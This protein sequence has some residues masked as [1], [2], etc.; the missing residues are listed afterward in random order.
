MVARAG[1][2]QAAFTAGELD[3][4]LYDRTSLKYF[5]TGLRRAE[6]VIITPQGGLRQRDGMRLIGDL[7]ANA[8]RIL[9]FDASN[10][11]S[12]DMVFAG[13][14]CKV[15][16]ATSETASITIA[17]ISALLS[18]MTAAQRLDTMLLFH[19]D[20]QSKRLRITDTGWVVDNLPYA[21]IQNYDYGGVYSNGIPAV[22]R[23]EFVGLTSGTTIFTLKV[24]QQETNSITFSATPATMIS[25]IQA[26][27][28]ALPNVASGFT[29]ANTGT[30]IYTIS[31]SGA[32]N[33]G[34]GWAVSGDIINKADAAIVAAKTTVGVRPGE[35][36][37]SAARGWPQCGVFWG[38]RLIVG[39][40]R[41]LP[42]AWLMS[43]VGDYF[44]FNE[45]FTEA[46]GPALV[47]MDVAGGESIEALVAS[48]NLLIFTSQAEYWIAE[49][50]LSRTEAPNHVQASRHGSLRG[51]PVT[52]NEGAAIFVHKNAATIGELRYT[53]TEGNFIA[54]DISLL[55][56]HLLKNVVDQAVQ[57]ATENISCNLQAIIRS[58]GQARIVSLLR[59][60]EVTAY[61][62]LSS[63]GLFKRVSRN[64]RNELS[65]LMD[66]NGTKT[67]ERMETGL[68][69]DE[70][71]NITNA[72][73]S[74][75][76]SG[77][78]RFNGRQIWAIGDGDVF[79]PFT[80]AGGA[81][82]LPKAASSITV[83]TWKAP[84]F[85]TLPLPRNV[86]PDT[87]VRRKGRIFAVHLSL[88]DTTSLAIA[89]NGGQLREVDLFRYGSMADVPELSSGFTGTIKISGLR[90]YSDDPYVQISQLRPGRLNVRSITVEAAL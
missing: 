80:V 35:P 17:G 8:A 54:T 11:Q 32:G 5:A 75:T 49:R 71:F 29:V 23:L 77:L 61:A 3:T 86:S 36:L 28:A 1:R 24:S 42:N 52:E 82:T 39:G 65:F 84:V 34:D 67:L 59:E 21:N 6:N 44:E 51:M 2:M 10:G 48:L 46:N 41:S 18:E 47:P 57:R 58:D 89:S 64:G 33:E 68:L 79:G 26:A 85:E 69:L 30:N 78:S 60:Q 19:R 76:V 73:A 62:R 37:I 9:P 45:R 7:P 22:W 66:R 40:L 31:F 15:W 13:N 38:Q 50:A 90:G 25:A 12:F 72:P 20:L 14:T 56:P 88:E 81:V 74:K 4:R 27:V 16:N 63:D 55:A 70:A 83:G 87:I 43:R 53:D